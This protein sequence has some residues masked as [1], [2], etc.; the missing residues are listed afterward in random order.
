MLFLLSLLTLVFPTLQ[1]IKQ[2]LNEVQFINTGEVGPNDILSYNLDDLFNSNSMDQG[3]EYIIKGKEARVVSSNYF[4]IIE[5][6]DNC[7][8]YNSAHESKECDMFTAICN[9]NELYEVCI[10]P[11]GKQLKQ[12]PKML[13]K[14]DGECY[15]SHWSVDLNIYALLCEVKGSVPESPGAIKVYLIDRE[16]KKVTGSSMIEKSKGIVFTDKR[17]IT[18][19]KFTPGKQTDKDKAYTSTTQFLIFDA[20]YSDDGTYIT[21]KMNLIFLIFGVKQNA[22]KEY[23]P[24]EINLFNFKVSSGFDELVKIVSLRDI[25]NNQ[26]M[27]AGF[28]ADQEKMVIKLCLVDPTLSQYGIAQMPFIKGCELV[29]D[30]D[31]NIPKIGIMQAYTTKNLPRM[32]LYDHL[33]KVVRI[34]E[35]RDKKVLK[36]FSEQDTRM[37][38][39]Q[40]ITI[41]MFDRCG[42][43]TCNVVYVNDKKDIFLG[44]D[45]LDISN[46]GNVITIRYKVASTW[47]RV[48]GKRLYTSEGRYLVGYD[49]SRKEDL[50]IAGDRLAPA[51]DW[52]IL[53][54]R[55]H[56][57]TRE[58]RNFTGYRVDRILSYIRKPI[59]L[60]NLEGQVGRLFKLPITRH[61]FQ[62]NDISFELKTGPNLYSKLYYINDVDLTIDGKTVLANELVNYI[63]GYA[64]K[65]IVTNDRKW[66]LANCYRGIGQERINSNVTVDLRCTTVMAGELEKDEVVIVSKQLTRVY[67]IITS[68][69]RILSFNLNKK[70]SE[71]D[72]RPVSIETQ[73][74]F[75]KATIT[76]SGTSGFIAVIAESTDSKKSRV[77]KVYMINQFQ[78]DSLALMTTIDE[79]ER[80]KGQ[81]TGGDVCPKDIKF[82]VQ[83]TPTIIILNAC[84]KKDRRLIYIDIIK[85]NVN[86]VW[87][88]SKQLQNQYLMNPKMMSGDLL[89]CPDTDIL[90]IANLLEGNLFGI[91]V[92]DQRINEDTGLSELGI[93][94]IY[95]LICLG[96]RAIGIIARRNDGKFYIITYFRGRFKRAKDRI[97]SHF[98]IPSNTLSVEGNSGNRIAYYTIKLEDKVIL[99]FIDL[100]GPSIYLRTTKENMLDYGEGES[101]IGESNL[102]AINGFH[103]SNYQ[104]SIKF[105]DFNE[106]AAVSNKNESFKAIGNYFTVDEIC[107]WDGPVYNYT[108]IGDHVSISNRTSPAYEILDQKDAAEMKLTYVDSFEKIE[109]DRI[110]VLGQ[111]S[112]SSFLI[113]LSKDNFYKAQIK[114]NY[115]CFG[116][117][118]LPNSLS[119]KDNRW[120]IMSS[121]VSKITQ[122]YHPTIIEIDMKSNELLYIAPS[123]DIQGFFAN[124]IS[125]THFTT[126]GIILSALLNT[127]KNI[128]MMTYFNRGSDQ[129]DGQGNYFVKYLHNETSSI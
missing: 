13:A 6:V 90:F 7:I 101:V 21:R 76:V 28:Y 95:Q 93:K 41:S 37:K 55:R 79:F 59:P 113:I 2:D 97:H 121:C 103:S 112:D 91:G 34:C 36:C 48:E 39:E 10:D 99:K 8:R 61:Y 16:K 105:R 15:D 77:V 66:R 120:I 23:V 102:Q 108:I 126:E 64:L 82:K 98:E 124:Q 110:L 20:P 44:V 74:K 117:S 63:Q 46:M 106:V 60:P 67:I 47:G 123:N 14:V 35:L 94:E 5:F 87:A 17:F 25:G 84:E 114:L 26:M 89:F 80:G 69:G 42:E 73:M 122:L 40:D 9:Q 81:T 78:F 62:G 109:G 83:Q 22:E 96:E 129:R 56:G 107:I 104:F 88:V 125:F 32:I 38:T 49:D 85:D 51:T 31:K 70:G 45:N 30:P 86:N 4:S 100:A 128:L 92:T 33:I 115:R 12:D 127:E 27:I 58:F 24:D 11:V 29:E 71:T 119:S 1:R 68:H 53:A 43:S 19:T 18:S 50:V 57:R 3:K 52:S 111:K 65:M 72:S 54:E 75:I 118:L 116:L